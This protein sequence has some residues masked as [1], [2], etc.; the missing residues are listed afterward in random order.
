MVGTPQDQSRYHF[1]LDFAKSISLGLGSDIGAFQM[2]A[3]SH[4]FSPDCCGF[5]FRTYLQVGA[6]EPVSIVSAI[7]CDSAGSHPYISACL[8]THPLTRRIGSIQSALS[9]L[10]VY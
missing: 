7:L 10:F 1:L 4:Y 9:P 6:S 5:F 8:G 2:L 3:S